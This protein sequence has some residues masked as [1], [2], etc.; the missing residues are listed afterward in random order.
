MKRPS[1]KS[2]LLAAFS[3]L[4]L[5]IFGIGTLSIVELQRSNTHIRELATDW[6]PS[7]EGVKAM[8]RAVSEVRVAYRDH[9]LAVS[10]A[11]A[12]AAEAGA[13]AALTRFAKATDDYEALV[14][15][16]AEREVLAR[17]RADMA[18]YAEGGRAMLALSAAGKHEEAKQALHEM[19][20]YSA[21]ISTLIDGIIAANQKGAAAAYSDS[22]SAY[23]TTWWFMVTI[24]GVSM[25]FAAA[26]IGFAVKGVA[27]PIRQITEAMKRL[28]AGDKASPIPFSGRSDEIGEMAAAV[29]VFRDNAVANERLEA[30]AGR[31]RAAS[32]EERERVAH[33]EQLRARAMA[34]ATAGLA[35]GL[36]RLAEGD[37][38]FRITETFAEDFESLRAD[39]N[40]AIAQLSATISDVSQATS[41]ID[42]GSR[43]I[44][45]SASDLSKRT[46]Q[47]AA[48]LE[49]KIGRAHLNSSHV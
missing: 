38:T 44:S 4:A 34:Q 47:Q 45:Q 30:E 1:I 11:D 20:H 23:R 5:V 6:L 13:A 16:P 27:T 35:D 9:L 22:A 7:V 18:S 19:R 8:D 40:S 43:E 31:V 42:N 25:L 37:L 26:L 32:E 21:D 49:E 33:E 28:A 41:A 15:E 2:A 12:D 10:P 3:F 29:S 39:F 48:S 24:I 46:E 36:K 17:I 14:A